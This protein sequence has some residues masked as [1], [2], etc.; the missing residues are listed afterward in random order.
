[1]YHFLLSNINVFFPKRMSSTAFYV[2]WNVYV[3]ETQLYNDNTT[4]AMRPIIKILMIY[5][6]DM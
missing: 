5:V 4:A 6:D 2:N 3:A 1:M